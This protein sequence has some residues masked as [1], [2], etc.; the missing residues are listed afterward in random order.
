MRILALASSLALLAIG[1]SAYY[2]WQARGLEGPVPSSAVPGLVGATMLV[3]LLVSLLLR[4]TGLQIAFLAALVGGGLGIGRLLPDHLKESLVLH[5]AYTRLIL[6]MTGVCLAYVVL[7]SLLFVFR[8][9]PQR[10]SKKE[11]GQ[12]QAAESAAAPPKTDPEEPSDGKK[13][14]PEP[15]LRG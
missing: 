10:R 2:G 7:A 15:A 4:R 11:K 14:G 3:G 8:R 5:D 12:P 6:A 13:A 9:R 1:A